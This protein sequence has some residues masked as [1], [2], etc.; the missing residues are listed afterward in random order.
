MLALIALC[1][2]CGSEDQMVAT[3]A[4]VTTVDDI[5]DSSTDDNSVVNSNEAS[6][7]KTLT[8]GVAEFKSLVSSGSF[9]SVEGFK[10]AASINYENVG[11][12]YTEFTGQNKD[13][14][15]A[16]YSNEGGFTNWLSNAF[17]GIGDS[18][19]P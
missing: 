19:N 3:N 15:D 13:L 2:A 6:S 12:V 9:I 17:K 4:P 18:V 16:D 5:E 1:G 10:S 7:F 8:G 14:Y 11:L